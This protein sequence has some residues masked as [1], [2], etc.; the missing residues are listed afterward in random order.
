MAHTGV[1]AIQQLPTTAD[2]IKLTHLY[3]SDEF[4]SYESC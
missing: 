4:S 1:K 3:A 2:G